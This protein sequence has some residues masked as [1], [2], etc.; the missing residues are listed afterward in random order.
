[1]VQTVKAQ[2][3]DLRDLIDNFDL[4]LNQDEQ[5]FREW[6]ENLPELTDIEK[7]LLDQVKASYFNLI[8]YPPLLENVIKLTIISPLLFVGKFYLS[9]FHIKAEKSIDLIEDDGGVA[10]EGKID[11]LLLKD[12]LWVTVIESKKLAF[13]IDE[14]LAQILT[15]MLADPNPET[16]SFGMISTGANFAFVKLVRGAFPEYATSAEYSLRNPGNDLYRVLS[17]LKRLSQLAS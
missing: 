17:I 1:M 8:Q 7:Q 6:Q 13:S 5:F 11:I 4:R 12:K 15:Y 16:P 9:P 10:I 2:N 14:G 3:I